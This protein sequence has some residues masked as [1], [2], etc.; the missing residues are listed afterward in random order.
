MPR[1]R[2]NAWMHLAHPSPFASLSRCR[3]P[4]PPHHPRPATLSLTVIDL[5]P[6]VAPRPRSDVKPENLLCARVGGVDVVKLADFGS[7]VHLPPTGLAAVDPVAQGTTLYSPP[8]VLHGQAFS[9]AADIWAA[10]ITTC[11]PVPERPFCRLPRTSTRC[12]RPPSAPPLTPRPSPR[13]STGL[14]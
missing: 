10:G 11:A 1:V 14:C 6:L 8:E 12:A 2:L 4:L 7:A 13:P 9:T 3:L 5:P